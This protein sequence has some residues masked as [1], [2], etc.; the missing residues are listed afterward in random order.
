[1]SEIKECYHCGSDNLKHHDSG[2]YKRFRWDA[3]KCLD[4]GEITSDEP[5]WDNMKGGYDYE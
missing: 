3:Y 5:D 1:M 2:T 4:C